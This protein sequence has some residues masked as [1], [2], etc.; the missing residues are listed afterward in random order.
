MGHPLG[1]GDL[2]YRFLPTRR[3]WTATRFF[4]KY[5]TLK[6]LPTGDEMARPRKSTGLREFEGNLGRRSLAP[7]EHGT[8]PEPPADLSPEARAEW[9]RVVEVLAAQDRL[10]TVDR[11]LLVVYVDA[12]A[13]ERKTA[14]QLATE[15]FVTRSGQG[16]LVPHPLVAINAR[17]ARTAIALADRFGIG[18]LA[19]ER[20]RPAAPPKDAKRLKFFGP[21]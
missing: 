3:P 16:A 8:T 18:T 10:A 19:R 5:R 11:A 6:P 12:I 4:A 7:V 15:G 2:I 21:G 20:L 9:N 17:F 1:R 14:A 13:N